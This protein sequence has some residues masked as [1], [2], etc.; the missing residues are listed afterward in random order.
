[1]YEKKLLN[2]ATI[3]F[4]FHKG[5]WNTRLKMES[6]GLRAEQFLWQRLSIV[7]LRETQPALLE[8]S[9]I[10]KYYIKLQRKK[11]IY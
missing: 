4:K 3:V 2:F 8:L 7:I 5:N 10:P 6:W 9:Q 1:M 11:I